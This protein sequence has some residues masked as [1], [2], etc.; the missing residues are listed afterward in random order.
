MKIVR[1]SQIENPNNK[2]FLLHL[3]KMR[4]ESQKE[5]IKLANRTYEVMYIAEPETTDDVIAQLNESLEKLVVDGGGTIVKTEV[6]GLAKN[7]V[8]DSESVKT[9]I[10]CS[11]KSTAQVR[12]LLN[13]NAVCA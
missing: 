11:L 6:M 5:E 8:P 4:L 1:K 12:K 13:L 3:L 7:G 10:T 9:V 2:T